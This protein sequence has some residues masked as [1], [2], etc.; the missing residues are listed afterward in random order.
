MKDMNESIHKSNY[1]LAMYDVR[2]KQNFIYRST[3]IKEIIG[4]SDIIRTIFQRE[5]YDAAKEYRNCGYMGDKDAEAIYDYHKHAGD[6][7]DESGIR[8]DED[9]K[10]EKFEKRMKNSQYVGEV[11]YD[12]GGNFFI[13]Y[14][15]EKSCKEITY[16][17]TK[18]VIEKYVTL[19]VVCTYIGN[20]NP[21]RYHGTKDAPG[22]YER[23]YRQHRY[24]ENEQ[25]L[26][27]PYGTL[28]IVQ[29]DYLTSMPLTCFGYRSFAEGK[30]VKLTT[31][32]A[33]KY[34]RYEELR[35]NHSTLNGVPIPDEKI[36]DRM[37]TSKGEESLLAVIFMDGNNMG[38]SVKKSLEGASGYD[39][40]VK[41][42]RRF[43]AEIQSV[44]I[45]EQ[46][47]SFKA[48]SN[49]KMRL[50]IGAGDEVTVICN[51]RDAYSVVKGYMEKLY[52]INRER[53]CSE[54]IYSSC[55]GIAIFHSHA[56]YAEVYKIAEECCES[57]KSFMRDNEI[58]NICMMDYH[59]CQGA[60]GV[61]L[62]QIR[63]DEGTLYSTR[64]WLVADM[65]AD[66]EK[67]NHI[68]NKLVKREQIMK[69]VKLLNVFGRGNLKGLNAAARMGNSTFELEIHRIEAHLSA[70]QKRLLECCE[71]D[72]KTDIYA[73]IDQARKLI[74]DIA[75]VYD[76]WNDEWKKEM[77]WQE[78]VAKVENGGE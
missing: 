54:H 65:R 59:Y 37:V 1:V 8:E 36:L 31:E 55:A 6:Q 24:T 78:I 69:M 19:R 64:P 29:A 47:D 12:G 23:I 15:D 43:S 57:A 22:D 9:F 27:S 32:S 34:A 49:E 71:C 62:K 61:S 13:L 40:C 66:E 3:H 75:I 67:K 7:S 39:E 45:N 63:R 18:K 28:P 52:N 4:G 51:A 10:F 68:E 70:Y 50:V 30:K 5:F 77:N 72:M 46:A 16:L 74:E 58:Q 26:T 33:A 20:L 14:K 41:R 17:F 53:E 25:L 11:I 38:A 56:P 42:L 21:D 76:L 60:I 2:G 44:F 35:E 73:N 48:G